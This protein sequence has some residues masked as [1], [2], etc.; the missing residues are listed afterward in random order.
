MQGLGSDA[1]RKQLREALLEASY[2]SD[3]SVEQAV[4]EFEEK[5]HQIKISASI[6]Q[7][8]ERGDMEGLN[9]L[10]KLKAKRP[11]GVMMSKPSGG[12]I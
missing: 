7:A 5:A 1:A 2:Y 9:Q 11:A 8:K 12:S 10:L 4:A 6:Q 3:H